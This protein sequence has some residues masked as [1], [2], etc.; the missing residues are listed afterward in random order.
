[1]QVRGK[2]KES[3]PAR[4]IQLVIPTAFLAGR[5]LAC[6]GGFCLPKTYYSVQPLLL[7]LL[8]RFSHG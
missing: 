3:V 5:D 7:L 6:P 4:F 8:S 1:M 2:R